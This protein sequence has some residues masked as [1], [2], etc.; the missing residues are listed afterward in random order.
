MQD[1]EIYGT[2]F[3]MQE[4]RT[5]EVGEWSVVTP[6]LHGAGGGVV[7]G[8]PL[9]QNVMLPVVPCEVPDAKTLG[10]GMDGRVL[11]D[12]DGVRSWAVPTRQLHDDEHGVESA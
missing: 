7:I 12:V 5:S 3:G 6:V 9:H 4:T 1:I 10:V 11:C 8:V 2:W